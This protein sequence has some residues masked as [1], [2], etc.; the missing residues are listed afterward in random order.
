LI[1]L[2]FQD[3]VNAI[4]PV[5]TMVLGGCSAIFSTASSACEKMRFAGVRSSDWQSGVTLEAVANPLV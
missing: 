5:V 2:E 1:D 4:L 3:I